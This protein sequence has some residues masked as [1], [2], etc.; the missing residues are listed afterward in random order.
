[1]NR[2]D[3]PSS[4]KTPTKPHIPLV[5]WMRYACCA[6]IV[7]MVLTAYWTLQQPCAGANERPSQAK[8]AIS[9]LPWTWLR[10]GTPFVGQPVAGP[11]FGVPVPPE[12]ELLGHFGDGPNGR[13]TV[14]RHPSTDLILFNRWLTVLVLDGWQRSETGATPKWQSIHF[15][16]RNKERCVLWTALSN[17]ETVRLFGLW[18]SREAPDKEEP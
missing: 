7:T 16:S 11:D 6:L 4:R 1:M 10:S 3:G 5:L 18:I 9:P 13:T 2:Q 15:L 8:A 12:L 17:D 14:F